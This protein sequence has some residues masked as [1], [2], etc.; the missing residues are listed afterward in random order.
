M[1]KN[2]FNKSKVIYEIYSKDGIQC[3][4][5]YQKAAQ[6]ALEARDFKGLYKI[7]IRGFELK[8]TTLSKIL[9]EVNKN[10]LK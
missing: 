3:S 7:I 6:Q 9:Y 8:D 1:Q 5:N 10:R 4:A 2:C